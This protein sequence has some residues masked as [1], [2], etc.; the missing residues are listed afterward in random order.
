MYGAR[1]RRAGRELG[2]AG[3]GRTSEG[4]SAAVDGF[5]SGARVVDSRRPQAGDRGPS[6]V[7]HRRA[8]CRTSGGGSSGSSRPSMPTGWSR[9]LPRRPSTSVRLDRPRPAH[10][11]FSPHRP[12]D[13]READKIHTE[14]SPPCAGSWCR[15]TPVRWTWRC[16]C[17]T[18]FRPGRHDRRGDPDGD[19]G[20]AAPDHN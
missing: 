3:L 5:G 12:A 14:F 9:C 17:T 18:G 13:G 19:R 7:T 15:S 2:F 20:G 16:G 1:T 8:L 11:G 6:D 4:V 10:H